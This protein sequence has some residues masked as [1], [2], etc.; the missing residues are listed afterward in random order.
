MNIKLEV[1]AP[2]GSFES[3][4]AA[5]RSGADAVYFG[6]KD[7]SARRN[8]ENFTFSQMEEAVEYC[9]K[10]G[11]K[12]YIT[13]NIA[14][15][16]SE[17]DSAFKVAENAYNCGVDG[18]IVSDLGLADII[19]RR[20]PH[21]ELHASTQ[22]SVNSPACLSF[23]KN[24]GFCRVVPAREMSKSELILLCR[25]AKR[26]N[27]EVEVFVHGALCMCLSGQCLLSSVLGGRSGNRGLCAGPCRLP[28]KT[29]NGT[30]YDLS[31]KDLSLLDH[32][33]E[34]VEMGVS[35]LKIEGRMKR[36][37]YIAAAVNSCRN[38]VDNG[39]IP[40]EI[41]KALS[42]VF[43]RSGFT[44]GY[45]THNLG[46][47]MFGIR[48][49][50]DVIKSKEVL[51]SL[52]DIYRNER[53]NIPVTVKMEI[54]TDKDISLTL[55]SGENSVTLFAHK[56]QIAQNKPITKD[57][58]EK[59]LLKFGSTPFYPESIEIILDDGLFVPSGEINGL[60][61][62]C[63]DALSAKICETPKRNICDYTVSFNSHPQEKQKNYGKFLSLSQLP[64]DISYFDLIILPISECLKDLDVNLPIAVDLPRFIFDEEKLK[65]NLKALFN[66]GIKKAFC[67][68]LSALKIAE[69]L[70]F[71]TIGDTG[72]NVFNNYSVSVLERES[73]SEITLSCEISLNEASKITSAVPLGIYAY[74]N[75]ALM[76]FKNCPLKNGRSCAECN[77]KGFLTDRMGIDFPIRCRDGYS[78]MFN[79]K[80]LFLADRMDELSGFDF[81][82][83]S[84]TSE[85][86][87]EVKDVINLYKNRKKS[88]KEYTRGLYYKEIL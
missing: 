21:I 26:L 84:F 8:A 85:E 37:E 69:D 48:S 76:C 75:L 32:I 57:S 83:F 29:Q 24:L 54:K 46:K 63:A 49:K 86:K 80:P 4:T 77:K 60:R 53:Q 68:N 23:L 2:V 78:E 62:S 33:D 19:H 55:S 3:L 58:V 71:E 31:L 14:I 7:F 18:L 34:L 65:I 59:L 56:P 81:L 1:L 27:M 87:D 45:F 52:H 67:G 74:G 17:L 51:S 11:V 64:P 36:P 25:E 88:E 47:D 22:M 28:F 5:V 42:S 79:S 16:E 43:S 9:H 6:L 66:K 50:D 12:V 10:F 20:L 73:L 35:S 41:S 39:F 38:M 82:I 72:L 30:G 70:G 13:L 61:R 40:N 15:K 44:D